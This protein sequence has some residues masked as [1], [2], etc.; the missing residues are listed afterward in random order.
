MRYLISNGLILL[1][2]IFSMF[3]QEMNN[4]AK[5]WDD[6]TMSKIS[7]NKYRTN[8]NTKQIDFSGIT[9][10]AHKDGII[11][12]TVINEFG[13]KSFD[14]ELTDKRCKLFNVIAFLDNF[15]IKKTIESDIFFLFNI[16]NQ[17]FKKRKNSNVSCSDSTLTIAYKKNRKNPMK[18][19]IRYSNGEIVYKNNKRSL[20]YTFKKIN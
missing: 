13:I 5:I 12:G 2:C 14:F 15:F 7:S 4:S 20:K 19:V 17:N 11:K 6:S 3:G 16:D 18:E 8:I 1:C 10:I 9:V